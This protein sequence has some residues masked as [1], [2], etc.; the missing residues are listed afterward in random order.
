MNNQAVHND[1]LVF[2]DTSLS[3]I[4]F[5]LLVL[6]FLIGFSVGLMRTNPDGAGYWVGW[7]VAL[8]AL[9]A[10]VLTVIRV[11]N[12]IEIDGEGIRKRLIRGDYEYDVRWEGIGKIEF[13][14]MAFK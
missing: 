8:A 1:R 5:L 10:T 11:S 6:L 7:L 3:E 2:R 9:G 13:S 14:D 12:K 4:S